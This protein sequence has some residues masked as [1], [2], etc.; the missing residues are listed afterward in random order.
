M[1]ALLVI[2]LALI[3]LLLV[4][5]LLLILLLLLL[6]Q[7]IWLFFYVVIL[8]VLKAFLHILRASG[9][10]LRMLFDCS[11]DVFSVLV[12]W[13]VLL[14]HETGTQITSWSNI[15]CISNLLLFFLQVLLVSFFVD[16]RNWGLLV[17]NYFS[18]LRG[19]FFRSR[20]VTRW[21]PCPYYIF[22]LVIARW[23]LR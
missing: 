4:E 14:I 7:V 6:V 10:L 20:H 3:L 2:Q 19:Y 9:N 8:E 12:Y 16:W 18:S 15:V 17:H 1:L 23:L 21:A 13:C 5:L 11:T 22:T